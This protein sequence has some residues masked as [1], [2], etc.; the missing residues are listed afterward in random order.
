M[1]RLGHRFYEEDF[2]RRE[3]TFM[4]IKERV[5]HKSEYEKVSALLV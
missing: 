2:N 1:V 5:Q 3:A 4:S